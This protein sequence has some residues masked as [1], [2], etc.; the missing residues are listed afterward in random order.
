MPV[1]ESVGHRVAWCVADP[2]TDVLL[3]SI[4]V[5]D[6]SGNDPSAGEIGY[7]THPD[8]R[9]RG[10]MTE[11]VELVVKHAFTPA[12]NGGLGLRRL[13]ILAAAGNAASHQVAR[14][15]R[16]VEVG[17]ERQAELLGDGSYD[18]LLTF[19]VLSSDLE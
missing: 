3:A 5:F 9:S 8:A 19:D 7:W 4:A 6:L 10:I 18:D 1:A 17:R 12:A 16:F 15:V 2:E 14:T 11:A 13:Q